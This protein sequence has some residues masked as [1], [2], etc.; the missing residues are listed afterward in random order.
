MRGRGEPNSGKHNHL[1]PDKKLATQYYLSKARYSPLSRKPSKV[2]FGSGAPRWPQPIAKQDT[3]AT[4]F[5]G[6]YSQPLRAHAHSNTRPLF[7]GYVPSFSKEPVRL[8]QEATTSVTS[9]KKMDKYPSLSDFGTVADT[10]WKPSAQRRPPVLSGATYH[11]QITSSKR[12]SIHGR[13]DWTAKWVYI[14]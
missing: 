13:T 4:K 1:L 2:G 7:A 6:E 8:A 14:S 3:R 11:S 12:S 9:F 10:N 5:G